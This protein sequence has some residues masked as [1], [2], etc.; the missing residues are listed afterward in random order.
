MKTY[1]I[2]SLKHSPIGNAA[3]WWRP[4]AGGYTTRLEDAGIFPQYTVEA[5]PLY[6]SNGHSTMA[7]E[8]EEVEEH[9][10]RS[11]EWTTAKELSQHPA[12][13]NSPVV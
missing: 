8:C 2:I 13:P 5:D 4:N 9:A 12:I 10:W 3:V 1:Y 7:L 11:V 6:Y